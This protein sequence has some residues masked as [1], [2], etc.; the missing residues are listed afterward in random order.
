MI[1]RR[2]PL[3]RSPLAART[4]RPNVRRSQPRRGPMRDAEYC[5]WLR[6]RKCVACFT[7]VGI[8]E[9]RDWLYRIHD[10][11]H[12][13]NNGM[14]SKGPDSSCAPLCRAHHREYDAG[15]KAFEAKYGVDM[16]AEAVAHYALYLIDK[17]NR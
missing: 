12:T 11:A 9:R 15:R 5:G 13:A 14:R 4:T 6:E 10:A 3:K 16:Q 8:L 1:R 2:A 7:R 17:E